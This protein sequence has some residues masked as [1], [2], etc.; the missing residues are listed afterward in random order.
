V[1]VLSVKYTEDIAYAFEAEDFYADD[2]YARV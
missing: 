1:T 2:P